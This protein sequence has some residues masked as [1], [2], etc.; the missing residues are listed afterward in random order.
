MSAPHKVLEAL[1]ADLRADDSVISPFVAEPAEEAVLGALVA[2]GPRTQDAAGDYARVIESVREGY[3]LHY[4]T[5]RVV[6]TADPDLALLAGDYLYASGLSLLAGI[7]DAESIRELAELISL[8]AQAHTDGARDVPALW[9]AAAVAIA[10]GSGP[11]HAAAKSAV[12]R[13]EPAT[14]DLW[15][16][17]SSVA[18]Q[19]G[20]DE[21]L[22]AAAEAVGFAR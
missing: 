11:P 4:G 10:A 1:A 14:A 18:A 3:L 13:G 2:A 5:P 8:C 19:T 12:R 17:S 22:G 21:E 9:L 7:G 15:N 6:A 20:L 16:W